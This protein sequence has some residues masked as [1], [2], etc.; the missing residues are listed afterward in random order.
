MCHILQSYSRSWRPG[1]QQAP[2]LQ[3]LCCVEVGCSA[4][5]WFLGS[6]RASLG[7]LQSRD[8]GTAVL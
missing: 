5:Q 1:E 6:V 7:V 4:K 2:E 3:K 8:L